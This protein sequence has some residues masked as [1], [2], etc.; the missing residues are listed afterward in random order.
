MPFKR[1]YR[2]V[3]ELL[4]LRTILKYLPTYSV[5]VKAI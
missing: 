5:A 3:G 4:W 1:L 2:P